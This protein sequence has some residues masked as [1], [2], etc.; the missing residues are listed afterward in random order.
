MAPSIVSE[1]GSPLAHRGLGLDWP[2]TARTYETNCRLRQKEGK[3]EGEC[4]EKKG[5]RA[6][7]V[8][9]AGVVCWWR[10]KEE[11]FRSR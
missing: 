11:A 7:L 10:R 4:E 8:A 6:E 3:K 2:F 5:D 1:S 9:T